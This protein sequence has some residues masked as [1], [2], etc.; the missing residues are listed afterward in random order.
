MQIKNK[1]VLSFV[2]NFKYLNTLT[3]NKNAI[4][5]KYEA[6]RAIYDGYSVKLKSEVGS[7]RGNLIKSFCW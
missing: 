6:R 2:F 3:R 1:S 7:T 4:Q 5:A